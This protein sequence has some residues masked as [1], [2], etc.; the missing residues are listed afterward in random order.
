MDVTSSI[1]RRQDAARRATRHVRT[2]VAKCTDV[3]AGIFENIFALGKLYQLLSLE[4]QIPILE[5]TRNNSFINNF[6]NVQ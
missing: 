2:L 3:E 4:Q 5:T 6:A 1:Q